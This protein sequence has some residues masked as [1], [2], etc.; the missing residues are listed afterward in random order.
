MPHPNLDLIDQFFAAYGQRDLHGL[1]QVLAEDVR[2]IFP[3]NHPLSGTKTGIDA[4][5]AFFDAVG[6]VIGSSH[7]QVEK[8]VM[9]V[10]DAYV[11]EAQ[12]IRL[13]RD[14]GW[15]LDQFWCVLWT[16]ENGKI[17]EG[18]HLAS[19]QY[20]VDEFFTHVMA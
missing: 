16:F 6:R 20:A 12:H 13:N 15:S 5:V 2:W 19:D 3:G 11:A 4:V 8:L 18:R 17:V 9:G 10:D 14:D 1:R 7:V